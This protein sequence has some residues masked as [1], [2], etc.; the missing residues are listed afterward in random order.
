MKKIITILA[1]L[2][3][4]T[5]FSAQAG[6]Y[7]N[8]KS[9]AYV[10][11][12]T[13]NQMGTVKN[14]E[15][16]WK[17]YSKNLTLDKVYLET[18]R[19]QQ[20]VKD[21]AMKA[22]I[23]FFKS[24][25]I[26]VS[27][28][29]TYNYSGG[30]RQRW[31]SFCYS[32]PEHLAIIKQVAETTAGYFDEIVLDDYYFTNCKCEDCVE[33]KGDRSW[34]EFRMDLLNDV[35]KN[36]IV[37]PA[38]KVNPKCKVI[39][40]YPN[41]YDHFQGLGFDLERGPYTFDGVYTGTETRDATS[42]QH[43][44]AYESFGIIRYFE[45]L[46]PEHNF[47]GWVDTGGARYPDLFAEQLW[48]TLLAKA[49]E[50]TLFNFAGMNFPFRDGNRTWANDNPTLNLDELKAVSKERG[51]D[52]PTWGRVAE[53][54]YEKID[55][56]LNKLGTPTGIKAYKPFHA[57]GEDFLHNY[58]GMIGVPVEIV[59][60]FPEYSK[61]TKLV[62]LTECASH[63]ADI[64]AKMKTFMKAGGEVIV[65]SGFY[66][67]MQDKGIRGIFEMTV[68]D[69]KADIDTV[70]VLT[71]GSRT[72]Y[73]HKTDVP[74][75]I[76]LLTYHTN[77]SWEDI[78]TLQHENGWPLLQ[79]SVYSNGDIFVWVIPD[80]FSHLYAL[81]AAALNR[82][83]AVASA[84][85]KVFIQGP[86]QVALFTYDN[87]TFVVHSFHDTPVDINV[88][89]HGTKGVTDLSTNEVIAGTQGQSEKIYGRER[90]DAST[91][92]VT[93]PP[94]SFRAFKINK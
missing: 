20:F 22:A 4:A 32:N 12:G 43:L 50:I 56:I 1:I 78:S 45:Q 72:D 21:D 60:K 94:H 53:Y 9:V 18:Y 15:E 29:I 28:G 23:K 16:L 64:L 67:A 44:Q 47:G 25:G 74:V 93:I 36:C 7:K 82:Y 35:A 69:R 46:R 41:W 84:D 80:N 19:D 77:D 92:P 79:Y 86:S 90:F 87:D 26:E 83:R 55:P 5:A 89:V 71:G 11:V 13:V 40:K 75:K 30:V 34:G 76:P 52:N 91:C 49:P 24:K 10:T 68:T 81:P 88:V 2:F 8:F 42:E 31:E 58:L 6:H 3:V 59:S 17:T 61:D 65:T 27:G 54:A 38:H 73:L 70:V 14:W 37:D 39:V 51:I 85:T 33:A 63:D 62:L 48:F 66:R 57:I